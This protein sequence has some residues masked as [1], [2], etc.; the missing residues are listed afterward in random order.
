MVTEVTETASTVI[1][2][3]ALIPRRLA[4]TVAVPAPW[5]WTMPS[6]PGAFETV[7]T[8]PSDEDQTICAVRSCVEPSEKVPLADSWRLRPFWR[9]PEAPEM[10]SAARAA[11]VTLT[12]VEA[13]KPPTE[14]V[15]IALPAATPTAFGPSTMAMAGAEEV[16]LADAVMSCT[17]R[18][19]KSPATESGVEVPAASVAETGDTSMPVRVAVVT[20]SAVEPEMPES[21]AETMAVPVDAA[22]TRPLAETEATDADDELQVTCAVRSCTV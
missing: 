15:R 20:I 3:E 14:A 5:A 16:Q 6:L 19:E 18:S 17:V 1:A 7:T 4:K 9:V 8:A 22:E 10:E 11:A 13:V 12:E 2:A 21:A